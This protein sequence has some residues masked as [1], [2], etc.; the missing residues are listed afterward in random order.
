MIGFGVEIDYIDVEVFVGKGDVYFGLFGGVIFDWFD[1]LEVVCCVDICLGGVFENLV[2]EDGSCFE[3]VGLEC[4]M[5]GWWL[6]LCEVCVIEL[7]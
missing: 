4:G 2:V 5:F 1:L 6:C 3:N 7:C